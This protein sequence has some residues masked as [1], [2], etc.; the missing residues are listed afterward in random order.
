MNHSSFPNPANPPLESFD[1][2][3]YS[4]VTIALK[5]FYSQCFRAEPGFPLFQAS[6][7]HKPLLKIPDN[8]FFSNPGSVSLWYTC[9][10]PIFVNL[11]V[12][13][14][15]NQHNPYPLF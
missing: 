1:V 6:K 5:E 3:K 2:V 15:C 12:N 11:A 7:R 4:L 13:K 10:I 14:Q 9:F 8:L